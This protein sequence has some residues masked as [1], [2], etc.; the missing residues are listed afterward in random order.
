MVKA[1]LYKRILDAINTLPIQSAK[2]FK[3]AYIE[4]KSNP[5]IAEILSISVNTAKQKLRK[6]LKD[7]SLAI[8]VLCYF[9]DI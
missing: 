6:I 9:A 1:E 7:L 2:V 5:E 8:T 4:Q 3:L